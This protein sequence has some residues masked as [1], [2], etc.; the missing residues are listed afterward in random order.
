MN[1]SSSA[2]FHRPHQKDDCRG[3]HDDGDVV[4]LSRMMIEPPFAVI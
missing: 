2:G 1:T 4:D 3:L